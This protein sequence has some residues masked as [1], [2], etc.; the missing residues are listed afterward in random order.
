M[1]DEFRG[2][3][4]AAALARVALDDARRQRLKLVPSCSYLAGFIERHREY[5]DLVECQKEARGR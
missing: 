5:A 3:G 4:I 2:R 1:P